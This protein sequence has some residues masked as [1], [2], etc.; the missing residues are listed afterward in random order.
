MSIHS[1]AAL[2]WGFVITAVVTYVWAG[3]T[4]GSILMAAGWLG[5]LLLLSVLWDEWRHPYA[6]WRG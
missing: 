4:L 5:C 2:L 1:A 6:G 3:F